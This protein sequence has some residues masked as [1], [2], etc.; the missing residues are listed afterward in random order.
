MTLFDPTDIRLNDVVQLRKSHPCG[1][2]R[3]Q[4]TRLGAD[5]GLLCLTCQ[6]KVLLPRG[7]FLKQLKTFVSR[8]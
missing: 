4:V 7:Q 2:N 5:I 3:W 6:H 1:G 8:G